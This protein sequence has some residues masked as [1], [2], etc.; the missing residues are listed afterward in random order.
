[1]QTIRRACWGWTA[2]RMEKAIL[3]RH[4][5]SESSARRLVNGDPAIHVPL[6]ARGRRQARQLAKALAKDP[7]DLCVTSEFRRTV[8]TADLALEGRG[9]PRVVM[10]ELGDILP[11]A[12]E[13]RGLDEFRAWLRRKGVAAIPPGGGE[14]RLD[15]VTRYCR[16][17]RAI[18]DRPERTVLVVTHGLPVMCAVIAASGEDLPVVLDRLPYATP[19]RLSARD[20]G[21]AVEH[22]Q[23]WVRAIR[24]A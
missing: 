18:L 6:T 7:I 10:P 4:A 13:G 8:E 14:S 21:R 15:T 24:A 23:R 3:A 22:L 12:F 11:G 16:A 1:M 17:Y 20:L 19:Y 5:E 2:D 9:I